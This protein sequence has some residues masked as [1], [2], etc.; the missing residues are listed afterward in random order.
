MREAFIQAAYL[1]ASGLFI[2]SLKGL[3]SPATARRGKFVTVLHQME[4]SQPVWI[5]M[6]AG[7][8]LRARVGELSKLDCLVNSALSVSQLA[9]QSDD[10]VGLLA[11]GRSIQ[12]RHDLSR[13]AFTRRP[14]SAN[15]PFAATCS[16]T[17]N[18]FCCIPSSDILAILQVL[19]RP[20]QR[21]GDRDTRLVQYAQTPSRSRRWKVSVSH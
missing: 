10:R 15:R 21:F 13:S 9:M 6:D 5:I 19:P 2:L 20:H 1:A 8:L 3:S 17:P 14:G 7:R 12:Q 18:P 16:T 4:R 11:Y